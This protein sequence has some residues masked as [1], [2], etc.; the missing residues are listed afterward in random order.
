[1]DIT[2]NKDDKVFI[3][4]VSFS[5]TFENIVLRR[6]YYHYPFYGCYGSLMWPNNSSDSLVTT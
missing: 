5:V 1:M 3:P 6:Q 4:F 2:M